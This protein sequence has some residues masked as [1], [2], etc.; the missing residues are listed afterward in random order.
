MLLPKPRTPTKKRIPTLHPSCPLGSW[1]TPMTRHLLPLRQFERTDTKWRHKMESQ[2]RVG[3]CQ[4]LDS[5]AH[6][7]LEPQLPTCHHSHQQ[8]V[9]GSGGSGGGLVWTGG[10]G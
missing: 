9:G 4:C 8:V 7:L 6:R 1:R 2:L 10:H 3:V 5:R